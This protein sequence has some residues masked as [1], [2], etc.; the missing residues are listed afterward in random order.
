M[1]LRDER[2]GCM[3]VRRGPDAGAIV[4]G[5]EEAHEKQTN[6]FQ[7]CIARPLAASLVQVYTQQSI[8]FVAGHWPGSH[9]YQCLVQT[10]LLR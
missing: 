1:G 7:I 4:K 6:I 8:F 9:T 10:T 2:L 5:V 3:G